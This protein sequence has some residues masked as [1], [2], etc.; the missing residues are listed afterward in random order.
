MLLLSFA[1]L[2][3]GQDEGTQALDTGRQRRGKR[4]R[5]SLGHGVGLDDKL[6][7]QQ[8]VVRQAR[9]RQQGFMQARIRRQ[10]GSQAGRGSATGR[11]RRQAGSEPGRGSAT[12]RQA[13]GRT[14]GR[15]DGL[16]TGEDR[17]VG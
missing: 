8:A 7:L 5:D 16:K 11:I 3:R 4:K 13:D 17:C 1:I 12:D 6:G 9:V 15:T 10:A 14:D 2:L